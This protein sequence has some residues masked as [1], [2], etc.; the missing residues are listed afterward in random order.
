MR[1]RAFNPANTGSGGL[2]GRMQDSVGAGL[3]DV[4]EN[5]F[6]MWDE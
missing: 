2:L 6:S 5:A 4:T 1:T 3:L